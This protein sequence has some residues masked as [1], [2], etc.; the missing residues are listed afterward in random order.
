MIPLPDSRHLLPNLSLTSELKPDLTFQ[1]YFA[2]RYFV[3]KWTS[4]GQLRCLELRSSDIKHTKPV[5]TDP[6]S[7]LQKHKYNGRYDIFWHFVA[8]LLSAKGG[9]ETFCFFQALE[10]EPRDLLGPVHQRLVMHCL[11][12]VA[13]SQ[14]TRQFSQLREHLEGQLKQWLLFECNFE[15]N[16]A[17]CSQLAAEME[18]PEQILK[19]ILQKE[20]EDLKWKIIMVGV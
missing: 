11:S 19:D 12:E 18:F 20:S 13:L 7:Y 10:D 17:G 5:S 3:R 14:E 16:N 4:R 9:E 6:I 2:A 15:F 8:G 1:E